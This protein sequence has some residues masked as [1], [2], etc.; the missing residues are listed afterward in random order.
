MPAH[1]KRDPPPPSL[2]LLLLS[3]AAGA[4]DFLVLRLMAEIQSPEGP[5]GTGDVTGGDC[6]VIRGRETAD[7]PGGAASGAT[8]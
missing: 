5:D 1:L 6:D 3:A 7:E 2:R 8:L 4:V